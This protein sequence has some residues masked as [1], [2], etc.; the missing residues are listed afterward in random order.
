MTTTK[1]TTANKVRAHAAQ[2]DAPRAPNKLDRLLGELARDGGSTI[3]ELAAATGWQ[4]HSVRGA[5]A[6]TLKRK[7]HEIASVKSNGVRRYSLVATA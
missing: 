2:A 5:M 6:G 1:T 3:E 7:G 4:K